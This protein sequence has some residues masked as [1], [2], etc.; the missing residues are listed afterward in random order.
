MGFVDGWSPMNTDGWPAPF[1][2][3]LE[4]RKGLAFELVDGISL[5]SKVDWAA[6]GLSDLGHP[7]GFHER[8]VREALRL[9]VDP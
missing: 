1:D 3:D 8:Q 9:P 5:L 6:K 2:T 4:A 7:D